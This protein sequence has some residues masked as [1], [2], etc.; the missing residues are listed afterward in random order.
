VLGRLEGNKVREAIEFSAYRNRVSRSSYIM[1]YYRVN[2][3]VCF[4]E[5]WTK[6]KSARRSSFLV[7]KCKAE[8]KRTWGIEKGLHT[9]KGE[10]HTI[11]PS[12]TRMG[13]E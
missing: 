5:D 6:L 1:I 13:D 8:T 2:P 7:P 10:V 3:G 12:P 4:W 11:K 9:V